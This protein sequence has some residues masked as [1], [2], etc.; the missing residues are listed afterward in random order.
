[1]NGNGAWRVGRRQWTVGRWKTSQTCRGWRRQWVPTWVEISG[2]K[3]RETLNWWL[4]FKVRSRYQTIRTGCQALHHHG[5][6]LEKIHSENTLYISL[7][8]YL[9]TVVIVLILVIFMNR[10]KCWLGVPC[11]RQ[12]CQLF[13]KLNWFFNVPVKCWRWYETITLAVMLV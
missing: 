13:S 12:Q 5:L 11:W 9:F 6:Y 2:F 10:F 8:F 7:F 3:F 4:K 1:M